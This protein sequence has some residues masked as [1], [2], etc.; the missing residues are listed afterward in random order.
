MPT[1]RLSAVV[2]VLVV[3]MTAFAK[4]SIESPAEIKKTNTAVTE[5]SLTKADI[6]HAK[7]WKLTE[8]EYE[9]Y[10]QILK[11]PRAYFTPNLDKNPLL[12]LALES[13][14]EIDKQR[15]A[16]KWIQIQFENNIKIISWQLEVNEAWERAFPGVPRFAYKNPETSH[17]AVA[18]MNSPA[19]KPDIF[20]FASNQ[21]SIEDVFKAK[22]RAQLYL[23]ISNCNGCIDA[24]QR[25]Y[26]LL[27][28]GKYSG[29]D[30]HF[31]SNPKIGRAH[32]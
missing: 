11:S 15:Y 1:Y 27:K 6:V 2:M 25:Q 32:V 20:N 13:E 22:P 23:A 29:L 31:V 4:Q 24:Y 12:A 18:N 17:Y 19:A 14:S 3:S 8:K 21:S 7:Q 16:D 5:S 28:S 30:I 9:R 10:K 26:E